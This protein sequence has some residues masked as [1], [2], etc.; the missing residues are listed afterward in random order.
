MIIDDSPMDLLWFGKTYGDS[1]YVQ[2]QVKPDEKRYHW[3]SRVPLLH[4]ADDQPQPS[5]FLSAGI[6]AAARSVVFTICLLILVP[7][8]S[9]SSGWWFGTWLLFSPN[10]SSWD[11]DPI[12]RTHIFQRGSWNHQAGTP[13]LAERCWHVLKLRH[14]KSGKPQDKPCPAGPELVSLT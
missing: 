9:G 4:H 10:T 6:S 3:Y 2:T 12:W 13:I 11:D 14:M 7:T 5:Q 1:P 8:S